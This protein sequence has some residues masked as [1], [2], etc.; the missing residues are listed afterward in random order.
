MKDILQG[1]DNLKCVKFLG[2]RWCG[3]VERMQDR[4]IPKR[5]AADTVKGTRKRGGP[6]KRRRDKAEKD[7]SHGDNKQADNG[8]K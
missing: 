7:I 5:I 8:Q 2:Q 4:R 3:H 6:C 1:T